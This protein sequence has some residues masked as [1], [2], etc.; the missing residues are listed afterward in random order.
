M[1]RANSGPTMDYVRMLEAE[2]NRLRLWL[3][4]IEATAFIAKAP[5]EFI[6]AMAKDALAGKPAP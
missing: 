1:N 5:H 4:A 6:E 3:V 2:R